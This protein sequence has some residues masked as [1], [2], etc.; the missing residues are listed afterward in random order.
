MAVTAVSEPAAS[1]PWWRARYE[2]VAFLAPIVLF[3]LLAADRLRVFL[4]SHNP[5][6]IANG[7]SLL[8]IM[9]AFALRRTPKTVDR[10][11]WPWA[12]AVG[13]DFVPF[14]VDLSGE[15][16]WA[17]PAPFIIQCFGLALSCWAV[18][19]IREAI[20]IVPANRGIKVG[21]PY[22]FIRHP[23]YTAVVV[24]HIGMVMVYPNPLNFVMLA[25]VTAFKAK[26]V[27]NEERL[28]MKDPEYATYARRVR[29]RAIPRL[30]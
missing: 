26:M 24:S 12:V 22:G 28:L 17:G 1:G 18:W 13:G 2:V 27:L 30:V 19:N 29:W 11:F 7:A 5:V 14:A 8:L 10:S 6:L 25:V 23:M 16:R 21:G 4:D 3:G 20:G 15:N 9:Y